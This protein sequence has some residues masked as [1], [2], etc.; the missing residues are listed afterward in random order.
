MRCF[1]KFHRVTA[2]D[3]IDD[4]NEVLLT[5]ILTNADGAIN[6]RD[7]VRRNNSTRI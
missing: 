6:Y 7:I 1:S 5:D 3:V 2:I 4:E